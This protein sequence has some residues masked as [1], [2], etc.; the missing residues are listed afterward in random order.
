MATP[1]VSLARPA[2]EKAGSRVPEEEKV[3]RIMVD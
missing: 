2:L 1:S 3:N